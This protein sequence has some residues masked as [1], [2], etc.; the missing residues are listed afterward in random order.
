M[1]APIGI[2]KVG[3]SSLRTSSSLP[4]KHTS[5]FK[6][7]LPRRARLLKEI[8][9][10][11]VTVVAVVGMCQQ[12]VLQHL[13][14]QEHHH[15]QTRLSGL[16]GDPEIQDSLCPAPLGVLLPLEG[17]RVA[18]RLFRLA[19][20]VGMMAVLLP[21]VFKASLDQIHLRCQEIN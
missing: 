15:P 1:K 2:S 13:D 11:P 20:L 6:R 12:C 16:E 5:R 8:L 17:K 18:V 10:L 21:Q 3:D 14:L 9:M 19:A 4:P 7:S